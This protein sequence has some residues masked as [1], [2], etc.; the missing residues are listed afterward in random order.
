MRVDS[1]NHWPGNMTDV[2]LWNPVAWEHDIGFYSVTLFP[3][4]M[5]LD[6]IL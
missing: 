5:K 4:N 3:G 1:G 6:L 2:R